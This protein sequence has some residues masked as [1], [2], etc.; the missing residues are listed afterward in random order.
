METKEGKVI[1]RIL[2]EVEIPES[3]YEK[4]EARYKDIGEWLERDESI[5]SQFSPHIFPQGSFRLGT[6]TRP[7][8]KQDE[9]DLDLACKLSD[10]SKRA[11]SQKDLKGFLK[12]DL[13]SYRNARQVK[14]ELDEKKR[15]WRLNYADNI[16][17]HI[18]VVPAIPEDQAERQLIKEAMVDSGTEENLAERVAGMTVAIT[19]NTTNNYGQRSDDWPLSNPAGY[20]EW[21]EF[22]MKLARQLLKEQAEFQ[23]KAEIDDLPTYKWKSPLQQ[24]V[25]V[26]KRHRDIMYKDDSDR[27][28]I[29]IIITTLAARAYNGEAT[30]GGA[31]QGI[32]ERMHK[33]VYEEIP[34]IPNPVNPAEDFAD[35]WYTLEGIKL[36]LEGNFFQWLEKARKDFDIFSSSENFELME[37]HASANFGVSLAGA[38]AIA[39]AKPD[40]PVDIKGDGRFG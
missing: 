8:T 21:F 6:V 27:K 1:K 22:R 38:G 3:A 18:D 10:L 17:F 15:C 7:L 37:K 19:D 36:D 28:P 29:S 31:V 35:N 30:V 32:L 40:S 2:E 12:E 4:A 11:V 9:Y 25:Q 20:A 39:I 23:K 26:L 5:S 33:W 13:E 34:K 24:A 14:D 16:K